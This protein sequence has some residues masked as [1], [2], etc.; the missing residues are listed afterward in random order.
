LNFNNTATSACAKTIHQHIISHHKKVAEW[1]ESKRSGKCFPI[2]SSFDL[3]DSGFKVAPVDANIFPAG[4]NNICPADFEEACQTME[5]YLEGR[6]KG[7]LKRV[8]LLTEEHTSNRFYWDNV[9]S[10]ASILRASSVEVRVCI[11]KSFKG[12]TVLESAAGHKIEVYPSQSTAGKLIIG[13]DWAPDLVVS[14]NDFSDPHNEWA[15][16]LEVPFNP[17]RELGW[18]NRKKSEHFKYYNQL[19]AELC[20]LVDLDPWYLT[21]RS[22]LVEN[23]DASSDERLQSLADTVDNMIEAMNEDYRRQRV[24]SKPTVFIKNNAGTYG[25]AV[26]KVESGSEVLEWNSKTRK[27]MQAAKGASTVT[28]LLVQEGIPSVIKADLGETAEPVIYMIGCSVVGGFLRTHKD[29]NETESLN[30]P[31][32]VFKKLC[33]SDLIVNEAGLPVENVYGWAARLGSLAIGEEIEALK[34][35]FSGYCTQ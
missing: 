1:F 4:F 27:K 23:F 5:R 22:E 13:E 25:L 21:V 31:G 8:A 19:A 20:K 6:Y 15:A 7:A 32:A 29:K 24:D 10:L 26:I 17:A 35:Q 16:D 33:M 28:S 9:H 2:Y 12:V 30:S 14:N 34:L 11:P 18:Y 3:R